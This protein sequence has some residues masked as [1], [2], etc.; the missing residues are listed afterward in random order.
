MLC[1]RAR[2]IDRHVVRLRDDIQTGSVRKLVHVLD[3]FSE[4][5]SCQMRSMSLQEIYL[6]RFLYAH[7]R[8]VLKQKPGLLDGSVLL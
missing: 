6:D 2:F 3:Q 5:R 4:G 7:S 1:V 8:F